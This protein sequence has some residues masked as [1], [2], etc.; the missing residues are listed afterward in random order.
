MIARIWRASATAD[1][2][3]SYHRHFVAAVK[4]A[5]EKTDGFRGAT[6]LERAAGET[7]EIEV[8]TLWESL[9]VI[10]NF[11]GADI[12]SAVVELDADAA[13]IDYERTVRHFE[14][15]AEVPRNYYDSH[16]V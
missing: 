15:T 12:D 5:L 7:T 13:L 4:P 8:V 2:A 16:E 11:A 10:R 9:E 3:R 14:V 6:L 1:G